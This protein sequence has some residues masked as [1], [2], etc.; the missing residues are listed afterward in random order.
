MKL[1]KVF[2]PCAPVALTVLSLTMGGGL[3]AQQPSLL[4]SPS[5]INVTY[6]VNSQAPP[7]QTITVISTGANVGVTNTISYNGTATNWLFT[8]QDSSTTPTHIT[9]A[10]QPGSLS[11]GTYTAKVTINAPGS[12][13]P[14]TDVPIV[15]NV[16]S[17][18]QLVV[19]PTPLN[20]TV[21]TGAA[22]SNQPLNVN[23]S[24]SPLNYSVTVSSSNTPWLTVPAGQLTT[25]T[26]VSVT[27]NPAG[28]T[29]GGYT[30]QIT[31]VS[32]GAS[33]SPLTVPVNLTVAAPTTLSVTPTNIYFP[34]Q[35]NV[36]VTAPAAQSITIANSG[37]T[38]STSVAYQGTATGWLSVNGN[39]SGTT[40]GS[41]PA[42]IQL[43]AN[44]AGLANGVYTATL[45]ISAPGT[46]GAVNI[47]VTLAVGTGP[48]IGIAPTSITFNAQQGT[49]P[50]TQSVTF[51]STSTPLAFTI[52]KP[53]AATWLFLSALAGNT[54]DASRQLFIAAN[55]SNLPVG[56]YTANLTV[57]ALSSVN[58]PQTIPVTLNVLPQITLSA[59]PSSLAFT[60][61]TG[62]PAPAVQT[63]TISSSDA[64]PQNFTLKTIT[65]D[66]TSWLI[67]DKTAGA[68]GSS[69]GNTITVG[70]TQAGLAA[71]VYNG[72][73]VVTSANSNST[74]TIPVTFTLGGQSSFTVTPASVSFQQQPGGTAPAA[75]TIQLNTAS[76]NLTFFAT[77][78]TTSGG[79]WLAVAPTVGTTASGTSTPLT[80]TVK[81]N[82]LA[83]GI[84][85]GT[86][87]IN[88]A[89]SPVTVPVTLTVGT[90]S[91]LT[92]TPSSVQPF[93][94]AIGG[95]APAAQTVN[96][97]SSG[98]PLPFTTAVSTTSGGNWLSV[99]SAG[100]TTPQALSV[101]VNP[102]G[103]AIGSYTGT[104]TVSSVGAANPPQ[105]FTVTL[106]VT[107]ATAP[108]PIA[109][110]NAASGLAGPIA[111]GEIITIGGTAMGPSPGVIG[112]VNSSGVVDTTLSNTRVLFDGVAAP[113]LYA[114]D[115]QI[116]T[117]VPYDL[118]GRLSTNIQV[119]YQGVRSPALQFRVADSA[120]GIFTLDQ[121]GRNQGAILNQDGTV[122]GPNFPA[123]KG[124]VVSIYAT[125]EGQTTPVGINGKIIGS[126]LRKPLL[127]VTATI[128]GIPAI[129]QYAGSAPT[130][131][132]GALQVNV[133]IPGNAPS[134]ALPVQL[135]IGG[136]T[137][138]SQ[139]GVTLVVR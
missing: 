60:G 100:N 40:S 126:D 72:S 57:N 52:D 43:T 42:T 76:P 61:Q 7:P 122:N 67:V 31:I 137:Q 27:I 125:G 3:W 62:A 73:I 29:A 123:T 96:V 48:L 23:S 130:L 120:P 59:N 136:V 6:T 1:I 63:L 54:G 69:P 32:P 97:G 127:P 28:L 81:P 47:P 9:V 16:V 80:V 39:A 102:T 116:N 71:G 17:T 104:V 44:P 64:S 114:S 30:G 25:G 79:D 139:A 113:I 75:Q 107:Q 133:Q 106:N 128:N 11:V 124:S 94:F 33:N 10:F 4:I 98:T 82:N 70:V 2:S 103:L 8:G 90:P 101:I 86:I 109:V 65:A 37:L 5:N 55:S 105:S 99:S 22:A 21:Q 20:L 95:A 15:L 108:A 34:F 88:G 36:G 49:S 66:G 135:Q 138:L 89:S 129:V 14:T 112:T 78:T 13:N 87:T 35:S 18:S 77:T 118:F 58:S 131:V 41:T 68:T 19:T 117:I 91:N 38:Y 84:Y 45:S 110:V 121:S 46:T 12:A 85:S 115:K 83:A 111:P 93:N 53:A 92:L 51:T 119:E 26:P 24:G 56:T 74:V 134:G 50:A 132:S